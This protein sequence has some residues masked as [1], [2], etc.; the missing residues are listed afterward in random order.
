MLNKLKSPKIHSLCVY[1]SLVRPLLE[2]ACPVWYSQLSN[3]LTDKIESVQKRSPRI[4]YKEGKIPYSFLFKAARITTLK[5]RRAK[6]CLLFAKS[7]ISNPCTEDLLPDFHNPT[8]LRLPRSA[9]L[10]IPT[11]SPIS[12]YV[13]GFVKV[14][15]PLLWNMIRLCT[16]QIPLFL[17]CRF[18]LLQC[19]CNLN[20]KFTDLPFIFDDFSFLISF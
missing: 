9:S 17:Y 3:E 10:A 6:I 13:K 11:Y 8:T 2:Y 18:F 14:L 12:C 20:V 4:I 7:V 16:C 19:F 5:E 1:L 15:S